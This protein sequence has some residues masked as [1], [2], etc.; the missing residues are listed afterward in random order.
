LGWGGPQEVNAPAPGTAGKVP[1]PTLRPFENISNWGGPGGA[2]GQPLIPQGTFG[3]D[4]LGSFGYIGDG[5]PDHWSLKGEGKFS[6]H[7]IPGHSVALSDAAAKAR[8]L[9]PGNTFQAAGSIFRYDDQVPSEGGVKDL[10]Y[11][12]V[13]NPWHPP[14]RGHE[15]D[16]TK[17]LGGKTEQEWF[18]MG[19][20]ATSDTR[21]MAEGGIVDKP[22]TAVLGE[23]GPEAVIPLSSSQ[24]T[25]NSVFDILGKIPL[26]T[27]W[28]SEIFGLQHLQMSEAEKEQRILASSQAMRRFWGR[29]LWRGVREIGRTIQKTA[30][31][32]SSV[33]SAPGIPT[34][35]Y[36][37]ATP[38]V[39]T[40][41]G[42]GG[43]NIVGGYPAAPVVTTP[44][45]VGGGNIVGNLPGAGGVLGS[46]AQADVGMLTPGKDPNLGCAASVSQVLN[47]AGYRIPS[48]ESTDQLYDNIVKAGWQPVPLGTPGSV[49]I[50]PTIG[51]NHGHTG[52][53][54]S[55]GR[56]YSNSSATGKWTGNYTAAS[57]ARYYGGK[58]LKT[59]S[60]LPTGG[61]DGGATGF[62]PASVLGTG[63]PGGTSLAGATPTV[64]GNEAVQ[65]NF[66]RLADVEFKRRGGR[67]TLGLRGEV[68][69][70]SALTERGREEDGLAATDQHNSAILHE[71]RTS[72]R[73]HKERLFYIRRDRFVGPTLLASA[74]E[75]TLA[76]A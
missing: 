37:A 19:P 59:Y 66:G 31:S 36:P 13:Y 2:G 14:D 62:N 54:G 51:S 73:M 56:I 39:T 71:L 64:L 63:A 4:R 57:W 68:G 25:L 26:G 75:N 23:K 44:P 35:G 12:D 60:F 49:V 61:G 18:A 33:P 69:T 16:A 41:P 20:G 76:N 67:S 1:K 24:K 7:M 32:P 50:A 6:S 15:N 9:K 22:T 10:R 40:P 46:L 72:N 43:G 42:V 65:E 52:I 53:V 3:K 45:G 47:S 11:I 34:S 48:T 27:M 17:V 28:K 70:P 38:V 5:T 30:A 29:D 21:M 74:A 55:D 8:G 58:G